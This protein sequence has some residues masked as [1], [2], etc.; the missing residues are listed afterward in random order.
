VR[1]AICTTYGSPF[2]DEFEILGKPKVYLSA[3]PSCLTGATPGANVIASFTPP[4][5]PP[6]RIEWSDGT[7]SIVNEGSSTGVYRGVGVP[8]QWEATYTITKATANGCEAEII[9]P[10]TTIYYRPSPVI[11]LPDD[12]PC[13]GETA[14]ARADSLLPPGAKYRWTVPGT[15]VLDGSFT[16]Q[17]KFTS[18]RAGFARP[19]VEVTYPD[20]LCS[21][22]SVADVEFSPQYPAMQL[23][24]N[25]TTIKP[26][27][28]ASISW[29]Y[30]AGGFGYTAPANRFHD[31]VVDGCSAGVCHA[32]FYDT[33]G[34]GVVPISVRTYDCTGTREETITITVQP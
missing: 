19:A 23:R 5:R 10:Q 14:T 22:K 4:A 30:V 3:S 33:I 26:N 8:A 34:P 9:R 32:K 31:F 21:T 29:N 18:D 2:S 17:V 11:V 25:V 27:G 13:I 7:V 28:V 12:N 15:L 20:G 1:D 6:L 16:S 24:A